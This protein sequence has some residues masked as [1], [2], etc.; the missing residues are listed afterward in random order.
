MECDDPYCEDC[1]DAFHKKGKKGNHTFS[2]IEANIE[3][4]E[5]EKPL[6]EQLFDEDAGWPY[7]FNNETQETTYENPIAPAIEE[8]PYASDYAGAAAYDSDYQPPASDWEK[9]TDEESGSPYWY[10]ATTGESSYEDP[11]AGAA[12]VATT[13][14][15]ASVWQEFTDEE[16][17]WPYWYNPD[18]GESVYEDPNGAAPAAAGAGWQEHFD[19]ASQQPYWYDESSGESTYDRPPGY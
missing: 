16:S 10:N 14:D 9:L 8:D 2:A 6:W 13:T 17:G 5:K 15:A 18:T 1:Y 12:I 19:D 3:K 4:K 11:N 7:W